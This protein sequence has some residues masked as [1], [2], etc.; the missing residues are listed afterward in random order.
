MVTM[1]IGSAQ[2]RRVEEF[3]IS[4]RLANVTQDEALIDA[5]RH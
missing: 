1:T 5:N 2:L 3:R 4:S